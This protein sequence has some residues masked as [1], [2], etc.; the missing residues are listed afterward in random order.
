MIEYI[1]LKNLAIGD[2]LARTLY[3]NKGIPLIKEGTNLT[4]KM[5]S[6]IKSKGFKGIYIERA[7]NTQRENNHLQE[8]IIDDYTTIKVIGLLSKI[9]N[10]KNIYKNAWDNNFTECRKQLEDYIDEFYNAFNNLNISNKMILEMED[11]RTNENWL[12]YHSFNTMQ[13][14]MGIA[15]R[16]KYPETVVKGIAIGA[17]M[18]DIGK[19]KYPELINKKD[20]TE[21]ERKLLREHPRI[22]FDILTQLSGIYASSYCTYGC[23]QSHEVFDGSGYPMGISGQKVTQF[24]YI[25][26]IASRFDNLV[27]ITPFNDNPLNNNDAIEMIMG[28][29]LYPIEIIKA[30]TE[31]IASYPLGT[32]V[33]LSNGEEGLILKNNLDF[34]LRPYVM[35]GFN[36]I[37]LAKDEKYRNVTIL[38]NID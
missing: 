38:R 31:V 20:L 36:T 19:S 10:N 29:N 7:G 27:H 16:L 21:S 26:G 17:L 37:N 3:D 28:S 5:V 18:H 35:I 4:E 25:V 32:K 24:G 14:A 9:L 23:W 12:E 2:K 13:I 6:I 15:I 11:N 34:T 30:L 1:R 33:K 22:I 8:P